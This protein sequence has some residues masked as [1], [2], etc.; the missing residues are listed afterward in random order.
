[1]V[2]GKQHGPTVKTGLGFTDTYT[3]Q[4][5]GLIYVTGGTAGSATTY[6][7]F[8]SA[9]NGSTPGNNAVKFFSYNAAYS[10][11]GFTTASAITTVDKLSTNYISPDDFSSAVGNSDRVVVNINSA[12]SNK[13]GIYTASLGSTLTYAW[14]FHSSFSQ[15]WLNVSKTDSYG[16]EVDF[17]GQDR[18]LYYVNNFETSTKGNIYI[19]Q[20]IASK[21]TAVTY[22]DTQLEN[23]QINWI[24]QDYQKYFVRAALGCTTTPPSTAATGSTL[25]K[26]FSA[27][28]SSSLFDGDNILVIC[29]DLYPTNVSADFGSTTNFAS[30]NNGIY[31]ARVSAGGTVYF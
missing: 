31:K 17:I 28:G 3:I 19:P 24:E 5:G 10:G 2:Y 12:N 8:S 23:Y 1:M 6:M 16:I 26:V 9:T 27:S 22:D 11:S 13:N 15:W 4:N 18:S 20:A 29:N 7:L 14:N 21:K 30:P 25:F